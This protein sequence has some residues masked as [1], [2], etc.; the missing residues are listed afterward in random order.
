MV[1]GTHSRSAT[2]TRYPTAATHSSFAPH[3]TSSWF[4]V[5]SIPAANVTID[6]FDTHLETPLYAYEVA[7]GEHV[8][9]LKSTD[10]R[11]VREYRVKLEAEGT[12][13]LRVD[14]R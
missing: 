14:L 5:E 8:V 7:A 4:N 10:G 13:T 6:G 2:W 1:S 12:T 3:A 11:Y 9:I